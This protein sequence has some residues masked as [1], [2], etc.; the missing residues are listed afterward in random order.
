MPKFREFL[1]TVPGLRPAV[2]RIRTTRDRLRSGGETSHIR[3]FRS[4]HEG[5]P[6][7]II[8]NGPSL[9]SLDLSLLKDKITFGVNGIW[10]LFGELGW[11]PTYYVVEDCYVAEDDAD[12]INAIQGPVKIFPLDL[13]AFLKPDD[14]TYYVRFQRGEYSGF[15]RFSEDCEKIVYWGGTVTYTN[16]Q[17]A[18]YMG[19]NPIYLIGMDMKYKVPDYREGTTIVSRE[20]D[21]NHFHPLYFGP[22]KRWHDPRVDRMKRCLA[23]AGEYLARK[24]VRVLNA[25]RR[26]KLEVFARITYERAIRGECNVS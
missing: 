26:G 25:T 2:M 1:K 20:A 9:T 19:C 15:P 11:R 5:Q 6:A 17:L 12:A 4:I 13:R 24:G 21:V 18:H 8:G 7:W 10:L 14:S 16:L 3:R 22:G 23:Y